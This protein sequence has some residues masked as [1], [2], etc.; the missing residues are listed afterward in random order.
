MSIESALWTALSGL[1][2]TQAQIQVVSGNVANVQTPGYSREILPQETVVNAAQ[3]SVK[4]GAVQRVVDQVLN[5]NLTNQT[6]IASAASTLATYYQQ[7]DSLLGQVGSGA[8]VNDA[9]SKFSSALQA[10]SIKPPQ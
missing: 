2:A 9:L 8:T 4:T 1:N 6:T 3:T 5:S 7:I 10:V